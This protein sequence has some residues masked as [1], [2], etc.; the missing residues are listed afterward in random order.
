MKFFLQILIINS[1]FLILDCLAQQ[2]GW[3]IIPSGTTSELNS[4]YFYDYEVGYAVGDSGT[5]IKSIDSGKTWQTLQ[6]PVI[7]NLNDI[8]LFHRD[9]VEIVGDSGTMLFSTDGGSSWW[10]GPSFLTDNYYCVIFY[11]GN[12]ICGG[13]SQSILWGTY[14][15]TA[16]YWTE[17]QSGFFGGGI[18]GAYMLSSGIGFVA[19]E[20]SIFQ[21]LFGKTTDSGINWDFTAFYLN[22]NEGRA[23]GVNF[24]DINTGYISAKVWNGTGAI[25]K[26]IDGGNNWNSTAFTSPLWSI[27]FPISDSSLVG[28]AVGDQGTILKTNNAGMNWLPQQ[29]GT[30]LRLN[31][32]YFND[33]DFGFAVGENGMVLKTTTGGDPVPVELSSFTAS[34]QSKII[35]LSWSTATETNNQ[36]FEILR[37]SLNEDDGWNNLG[38]VPGHGTTTDTQQYSFTDYDV[39]VGKYRYR[40]KQI[41][42]DGSFEYSNEIEVEIGSP[43]EFNLS[44]NYPNPFNPRTKIKYSISSVGA[45]ERVSVQL[46][47]Y[48]VLGN[49]VA[50]LVNEELSAGEYEV[51]FNSSAI[52]H[53][54]SSGIYF[55]QLKAGSF[56][57]TK[58]MVLLK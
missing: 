12:G 10:E 25:A 8:Y 22:N 36:G 44:Q 24:T 57:Q 38:F 47:V 33:L 17:V 6:T 37:K 13:S 51:E 56:I 40:L 31:K 9:T 52:E 43:D 48:D 26:T 3:E 39:S 1:T 14:T 34:V 2:S 23:T 32:V 30:N 21:P 42:F 35:Y 18:W 28:Y 58:K 5:V 15:G 20:N 55:Y 27:N 29:S 16:L 54:P 49:E 41:D 7:S 50:T 53:D 11:D 19:G 4:I 45:R 46:I